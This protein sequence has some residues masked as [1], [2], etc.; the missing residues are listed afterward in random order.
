MKLI[1]S[2]KPK[3]VYKDPEHLV[4]DNF[5]DKETESKIWKELSFYTKNHDQIPRAENGNEYQV[6]KDANNNVLSEAYR[7]Y[8]DSFYQQDRRNLSTILSSIPNLFTPGFRDKIKNKAPLYGKTIDVVNRI[9]TLVSYYETSDYYKPHHDCFFWTIL[10]WFYK[11]PKKFE[12]GNF[13]LN[14]FET[15]IECKHNRLV[16]FPSWYMHEVEPV[17]MKE[18]DRF[19]DN[20]RYTLTYFLNYVE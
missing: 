19:Q 8:L 18:E 15:L 14:E 13:F 20:G 7:F 5:F 17:K 4:I 9:H 6:A 1:K 10:I 12:G 16:A 2:I 11:E 3:K